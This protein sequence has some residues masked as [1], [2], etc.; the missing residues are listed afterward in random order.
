MLAL[1][2]LAGSQLLTFGLFAKTYAEEHRP[3]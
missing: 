3:R 2:T 1:V